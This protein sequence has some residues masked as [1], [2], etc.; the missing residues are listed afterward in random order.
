[1]DHRAMETPGGAAMVPEGSNSQQVPRRLREPAVISIT[2]GLVE[3]LTT[4]RGAVRTT[5][6]TRDEVLPDRGGPRTSTQCSA[7]ANTGQPPW[8]RPRYNPSGPCRVT[9]GTGRLLVNLIC[10]S[11]CRGLPP[12]LADCPT[13]WPRRP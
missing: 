1:G 5:G 6:M 13:Y 11:R 7:G 10:F 8:P 12:S 9:V 4:A 3:V 2:S